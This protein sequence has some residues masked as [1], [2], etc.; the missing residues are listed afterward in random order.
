[1]KQKEGVEATPI[2]RL[3]IRATIVSLVALITATAGLGWLGYQWRNTVPLDVIAIS[4]NT[5]VAS[6]TLHER[7]GITG[8][9]LMFRIRPEDVI[10]RVQQD[11]WVASAMVT[12]RPTGT[13]AVRVV[14]RQPVA[15]VLRRGEPTVY[16][17]RY[18]VPMAVTRGVPVDVPVLHWPSTGAALEAGSA[19][20]DPRL[21]EMLNVLADLESATF[22]LI[23]ELNLD[24]SGLYV[25]TTPLPARRSVRVS[26]G[27]EGYR[28][29]LERLA[30]FWSRVVIAHPGDDIREI[31]LR[32]DGQIIT[33]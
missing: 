9:T 32:Y 24:A 28:E 13:L 23:S 17:D 25:F 4:G 16:L 7:V 6:T 3:S 15:I 27:S 18:G 8:D 10:E 19:I 1:M 22:D 26:M 31:D 29:K 20:E 11:P 5:H 12:R 30:H 14:E 21:L 33:S 2:A